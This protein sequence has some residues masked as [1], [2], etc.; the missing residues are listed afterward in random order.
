MHKQILVAKRFWAQT[1]FG[2]KKFL[3]YKNSSLK[4][5]LGLKKVLAQKIGMVP[6]FLLVKKNA[7]PKKLDPKKFHVPK[8]FRSQKF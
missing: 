4:K 2:S 3:V 6:I 7:G 8:N 1:N 5:I